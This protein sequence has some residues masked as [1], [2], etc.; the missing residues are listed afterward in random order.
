MNKTIKIILVVILGLVVWIV[1]I[2]LV[3][4]TTE[5]PYERIEII[6]EPSPAGIYDPSV[7]YGEDGIGWM[8]YSAIPWVGDN[9]CVETHLAK[10]NDHGKTWEFVSN[11]NPCF[12]D[13]I[14]EGGKL[15]KGK[16]RYEV[17]TILHDPD[18]PGK[19]W[20]LFA[21]RF[22]IIPPDADDDR[23]FKHGWFAY[24]YAT[25]PAGPWSEEIPLLGAGEFVTSNY[26]VKIN[27]NSLS[28]ELKDIKFYTE[29]GSLY[30]DGVIYL[31]M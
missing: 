15:I 9:W 31:S 23:I 14:V 11:V 24:K 30:K 25:N 10:S 28:P 2:N 1:L 22:F 3:R 17:A 18:D 5:L 26:N 7:E 4:W 13:S 27:L 16:W 29:M 20:K 19:E 6:G 21:H 12:T 8:A